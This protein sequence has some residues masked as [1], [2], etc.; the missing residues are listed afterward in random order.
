MGTSTISGHPVRWVTIQLDDAEA[1]RLSLTRVQVDV[2]YVT[3]LRGVE[4][5]LITTAARAGG[6][7]TFTGVPPYVER[8]L[9]LGVGIAR[10]R[11][12]ILVNLVAARAE[13]SDFTSQLLRVSKVVEK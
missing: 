3:P 9:A 5:A 13:G 10:E 2:I 12:Q 6:L 7:T 8:G 4:L 1:L 11:P